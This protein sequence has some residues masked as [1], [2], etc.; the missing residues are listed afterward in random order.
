MAHLPGSDC[1]FWPCFGVGVVGQGSPV[2]CAGSNGG[3]GWF[4][5]PLGEGKGLPGG[6]FPCLGGLSITPGPLGVDQVVRSSCNLH[7]GGTALLVLVEIR[8][9]LGQ[10]LC[11]WGGGNCSLGTGTQ[12]S[13]NHLGWLAVGIWQAQCCYLLWSSSN[14]CQ[15]S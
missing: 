4:I 5:Q 12:V 14:C 8:T 10:C 13:A 1:P 15:A 6:V 11:C 3:L 7:L 9:A 2:D